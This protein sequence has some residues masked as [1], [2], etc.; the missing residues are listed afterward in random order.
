MLMWETE[1]ADWH[2]NYNGTSAPL[3]VGNMVVSGIA[4]GDEGVRGFVAA[5]DQTSGKSALE[6]FAD[7][8]PPSQM[9]VERPRADFVDVL[10][11]HDGLG[12]IFDMR[13]IAGKHRFDVR[14]RHPPLRKYPIVWDIGIENSR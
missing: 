2:Q 10:R 11:D 3:V 5:Y 1:M 9:F 14:R 4:G 6:I 8:N 7:A 13:A 12:L